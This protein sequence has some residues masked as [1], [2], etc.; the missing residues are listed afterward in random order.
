MSLK[1]PLQQVLRTNKE[2]AVKLQELGIKT[3][4]DLVLYFPRTYVDKSAY[5]N[6]SDL[7]TDE[8]NNVIGTLSNIFHKR[9][10]NGK[11]LTK[12]LLS[13][14]T[15]SVEVIWFNQP[16]LKRVLKNGQEIILSG[17]A[18]FNLGK[19]T[20]QSP[21][22]KNKKKSRHTWAASFRSITKPQA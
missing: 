16:Y 11:H 20:L 1:S 5:T 22:S 21:R 7:K 4:R 12:A 15:G 10:K 2:H 18:K 13:D 6:I 8:I 14:D 17:K 9:T 19:M 3:V